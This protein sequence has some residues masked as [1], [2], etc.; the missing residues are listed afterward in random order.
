MSDGDVSTNPSRGRGPGFSCSKMLGYKLDGRGVCGVEMF[1][2]VHSEVVG[3][4]A[5]V[6]RCFDTNWMAPVAD[7]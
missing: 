3:Q 2:L 6:A 5:Q 4:V 1:L 7:W